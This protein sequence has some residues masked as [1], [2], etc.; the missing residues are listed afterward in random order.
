MEGGFPAQFS[1]SKDFAAGIQ[2]ASGD[3]PAVGG[4]QLPTRSI[5]PLLILKGPVLATSTPEVSA[6]GQMGWLGAC[7]HAE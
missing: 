2:I 7:A 3:W 1:N 6:S 5:W 4:S